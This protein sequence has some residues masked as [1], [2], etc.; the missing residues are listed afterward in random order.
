MRTHA[1]DYLHLVP[2]LRHRQRVSER[3]MAAGEAGGW[4]QCAAR[5]RRGMRERRSDAFLLIIVIVREER[6]ERRTD[7]RHLFHSL[8]KQAKINHL[9][10]PANCSLSTRTRIS[11]RRSRRARRKGGRS[12]I[13]DSCFVRAQNPSQL[14]SS[15]SDSG[16]YLQFATDVRDPHS[17]SPSFL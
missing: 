3:R 17:R 9:R 1:L 10:L 7:I 12:P 16:F 13:I 15:A 5:R 4:K 6:K 11:G 2:G 14:L 8:D